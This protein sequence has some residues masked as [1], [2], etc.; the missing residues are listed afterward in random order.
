MT[1]ML[2]RAVTGLEDPNGMDC[3]RPDPKMSEAEYI[4]LSEAELESCRKERAHIQYLSGL[5]G[6][7]TRR[8]FVYFNEE[9]WDGPMLD[10]ADA[11]SIGVA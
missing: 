2:A 10:V 3:F 8:S 6:L 4:E 7:T 1:V 11:A 9:L 5:F